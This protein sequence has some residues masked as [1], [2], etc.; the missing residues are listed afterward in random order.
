MITYTKDVSLIASQINLG[1]TL[2]TECVSGVCQGNPDRKAT[3]TLTRTVNGVLYNCY[4]A[5]CPVRG[6]I[7]TT[8]VPIH[9]IA[10]ARKINKRFDG[11]VTGIPAA[12]AAEIRRQWRMD[13][14]PTWYY[15][16]EYGGRVAM[17]VRAPRVLSGADSLHRGWVLRSMAKVEG[18]KAL[19]Y[20]RDGQLGLSWYKTAPHSGTV[21]V[22]DIPSAVR[23]STYMNSVA[24]LGTGVGIDR[25]EEIAEYATRP[26]YLALDQDA[27][28]LAFK[29]A[30]RYALLWG[31]VQVIPLRQDIKNMEEQDICA[32]LS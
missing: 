19:T 30:R 32:L 26:L 7:P 13:P 15:T 28:A 5:S 18:P 22:E 29:I 27:T 20:I 31:D 16:T 9:S 3:L 8:G 14:P 2:R 25:A 23:A 4:R 24:L 12:V 6:F 1:E 11:H 21:L 17:S 10:P